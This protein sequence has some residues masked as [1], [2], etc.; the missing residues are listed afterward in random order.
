MVRDIEERTA[1][2][3]W[4]GSVNKV[5]MIKI[6]INLIYLISKSNNFIYFNSPSK[7]SLLC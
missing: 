6:K 5:D 1:N 7:M 2:V 4:S 3:E